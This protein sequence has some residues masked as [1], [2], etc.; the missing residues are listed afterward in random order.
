M[1]IIE[2]T[3]RDE[4]SEYTVMCAQCQ[5]ENRHHVILSRTRDFDDDGW[6]SQEKYQIIQCRGCDSVRFRYEKS[7]E[8]SEQTD[9]ES[10]QTVFC[11]QVE[12]YPLSLPRRKVE[13]S[14]FLPYQ[15]KPIY[16]EVIVCGC[17]SCAV[18]LSCC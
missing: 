3:N 14:Q 2:S 13:Y 17:A 18:P 5:N 9:Y 12:I 1:K 7:D 8:D 6:L 10:G 16:H 4:G 11:G 15:L